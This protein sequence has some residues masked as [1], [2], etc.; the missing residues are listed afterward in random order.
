MVNEITRSFSLLSL[1]SLL[2]ASIALAQPT[3][4]IPYAGSLYSQGRPVSQ[5]EPVS[6]AFA[7]YTEE[8]VIAF[9]DVANSSPT[10]PPL[11]RLW[12]SWESGSEASDVTGAP[13]TPVTVRNGAFFV[14]LGAEQGHV[15]VPPT[16]FESAAHVVTWV[17]KPN[18]SQYT[19]LDC[20]QFKSVHLC[21]LTDAEKSALDAAHAVLS[22]ADLEVAQ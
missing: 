1:L 20:R 15:P 21:R 18:G 12:T 19:P 6:M 7:L 13:A 14:H 5:P 4:V 11:G 9:T 16:A 17:I 2:C 8:G 22:D 10:A 3:S